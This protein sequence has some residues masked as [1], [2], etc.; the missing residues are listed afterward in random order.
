MQTAGQRA[1]HS[2]LP[3]THSKGD[4]QK[5]EAGSRPNPPS[6]EMPQVFASLLVPNQA[7]QGPATL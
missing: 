3:L 5:E 6:V 1:L 7:S 4:F 2:P